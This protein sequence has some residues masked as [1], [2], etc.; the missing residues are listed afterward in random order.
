[1][2]VEGVGFGFYSN[3]RNLSFL[4]DGAVPEETT[5]SLPPSPPRSI[6]R[7]MLFRS[8]SP[9]FSVDFDGITCAAGDAQWLRGAR[10]WLG[11]RRGHVRGSD[12]DP[13]ERSSVSAVLSPPRSRLTAAKRRAAAQDGAGRGQT[14]TIVA[15]AMSRTLRMVV[16]T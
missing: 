12:R 14:R 9:I 8:H 7:W 5:A 4:P 10:F 13:Y 16:A 2:I 11:S 1:M 3:A 15:S 6:P